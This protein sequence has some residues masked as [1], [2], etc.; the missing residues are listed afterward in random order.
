VCRY[1]ARRRAR[2]SKRY[3]FRSLLGWRWPLHSDVFGKSFYLLRR[4]KGLGVDSSYVDVF[5][6]IGTLTASS[7]LAVAFENH[8]GTTTSS[9]VN[10]AQVGCAEPFNSVLEKDATI[11]AKAKERIE[12]AHQEQD[13]V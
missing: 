11:F 9:N 3:Y 2:T 8:G 7:S 13:S 12:H 6:G 1:N 10:L 4:W 5:D